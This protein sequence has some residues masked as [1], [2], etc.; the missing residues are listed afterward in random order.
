MYPILA[1]QVFRRQHANAKSSSRERT[2]G[3]T[4]GRTGIN[5]DFLTVIQSTENQTWEYMFI[6]LKIR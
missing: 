1:L 6:Y 5:Y 2:E 3:Q 4:V